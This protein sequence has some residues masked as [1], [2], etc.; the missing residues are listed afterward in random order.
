[1]VI[2][3]KLTQSIAKKLNVESSEIVFH[4]VPLEDLG[5]IALPCF[6]LAKKYKQAPALLAVQLASKIPPGGLI[7]KVHAV[8]PYINIFLDYKKVFALLLKEKPVRKNNKTIVLDYS[9][10]NIAKPFGVGHLRST[11]IGESLKRVYSALGYRTIAINHLGDWG[12]QFGK[13]IVAY[14]KWPRS[15]SRLPIRVLYNLYV[16]FH[17]ESE[18]NPLL[19]DEARVWFKKLEDGDKEAT[20]LWRL[21]RSLS[22]KDFKQLYKR[23]GCSFQSYDGE[24]Y[25]ND[26]L[27][28]VVHTLTRKKLLQKSEGADIVNLDA[29]QLP[30]GLI[31]KSDGAS[32]YLTRDIAAAQYRY[33]TYRFSKMIYEVGQEQ[34]L[35][36]R[37]LF[38][39][40]EL[41][42][43]AWTD[44]C[45]HVSHGH[46]H[47]EGK[48]MSTRKGTI[49]FVEDLIDEVKRAV[50]KIIKQKNPTL[51]RRDAVA[52]KIALGAIIFHDLKTD[53]ENAVEFNIAHMTDFQG[54]TGPY[55]LYTY[56]RL[57]SILKKG[58]T[59]ATRSNPTIIR[60]IGEEERGMIVMLALFQE[61][62]RDVIEHNKPD[63]LAKYLITLAKKTNSYYTHNR[64]LQDN[65]DIQAMRLAVIQKVAA[66]LKE[67][68][69]LLG[70]PIIEE[71]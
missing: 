25:F 2:R 14:K 9:S 39:I 40:L 20:K 56:T 60:T 58:K 32:L 45:M 7:K 4:E 24:A 70:M 28:S 31:R 27:A 46:Y 8:G 65:A 54:E 3:K 13:L 15:L 53:R 5:D 55:I 59:R 19:E 67:G 49:I 51:K 29:F 30:P 41:M 1:M 33:A 69:Y 61:T 44:R 57:Q 10:P 42:G 17:S 22:L 71:M 43:L 38:A 35:H 62:L 63:I 12:T 34:Q 66:T 26:K 68:M 37:Q 21:F 50:I 36:F 16:K 48:K 52:E 64:V 18:K 23:L 11:F 47:C 6:F